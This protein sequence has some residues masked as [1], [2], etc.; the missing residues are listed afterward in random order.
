MQDLILHSLSNTA[1]KYSADKIILFG[2]RARGNNR[3]NSDYDIAVFGMPDSNQPLFWADVED[4][5][6]LLKF[7]IVFVTDTTNKKLIENIKKDGVI[8][9]A[10][11]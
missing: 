5:S 11:D 8:L 2:S 4:I 3:P 10:K 6:T 9:Y 1:I 7:D